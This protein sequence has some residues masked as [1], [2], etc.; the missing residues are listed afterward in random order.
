MQQCSNC[1]GFVPPA[2]Q[3]CPHCQQQPAKNFRLGLKRALQ[4]VL[5]TS[6]T[7]TLAACYGAPP[8]M[9][10]PC[11][12]N[13]DT[14]QPCPSPSPSASAVTP[15]TPVSPESPAASPAS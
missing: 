13:K 5:G 6:V 7:M 9:P 10:T 2:L 15:V 3:V 1:Q 11:D 4:L 12:D 8:P 14:E